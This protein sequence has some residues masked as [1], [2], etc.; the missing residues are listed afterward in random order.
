[1][2]VFCVERQGQAEPVIEEDIDILSRT[3]ARDLTSK[4]DAVR[5]DF[6]TRF[7]LRLPRSPGSDVHTLHGV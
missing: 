5:L 2:S 3:L 4:G 6:P 1:M 7:C